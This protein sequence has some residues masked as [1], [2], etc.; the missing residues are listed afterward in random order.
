M[1]G[2]GGKSGS[3]ICFRGITNRADETGNGAMG[4]VVLKTAMAC[5]A[6]WEGPAFSE[7]GRPQEAGA[8]KGGCR[9]G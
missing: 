1:V 7:P 5:V 2:S 6:G 9:Q 3:S 8:G 4:E